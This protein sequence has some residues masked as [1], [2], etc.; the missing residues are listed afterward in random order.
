MILDSFIVW[1]TDNG[2][3]LNEGIFKKIT[4][5]KNVRCIQYFYCTNCTPLKDSQEI[6]YLGII[7]DRSP[8]FVPHVPHICRVAMQL[9]GFIFRS[10]K[11]FTNV[12]CIKLFFYS[13]ISYR[14]EHFFVVW[15]LKERAQN[16]CQVYVHEDFQCLSYKALRSEI[17][18]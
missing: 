17:T 14:L 10:T 4:F 15:R 1:C 18:Y 16:V 2:L 13:L 6:L 3:Q 8:Y 5:I 12:S 7:L 11:D 9:L